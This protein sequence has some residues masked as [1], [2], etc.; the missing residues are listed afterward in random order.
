M[1]ETIGKPGTCIRPID[2][3]EILIA[4]DNQ[5]NTRKKELEIIENEVTKKRIIKPEE[6]YKHPVIIIHENLV[7]RTKNTRDRVINTPEC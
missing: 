6:I 3:Q 5:L 1:V 7:E 2:R 4:L